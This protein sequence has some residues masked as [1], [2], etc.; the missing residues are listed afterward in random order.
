M[1]EVVHGAFQV[2]YILLF[3]C[4]VILL[5]FESLILKLLKILIKIYLKS[6]YNI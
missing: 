2:Y 1:F 4:I 6:I 3:L 5:I